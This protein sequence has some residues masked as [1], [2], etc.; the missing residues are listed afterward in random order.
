MAGGEKESEFC[1]I[2]LI[3]FARP[4]TRSEY[5]P[6]NLYNCV[7]YDAACLYMYIHTHLSLRS[8]AINSV[9]F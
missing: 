5:V 7:Y 1:T 9:T 6:R 2:L 4:R 3:N 8:D